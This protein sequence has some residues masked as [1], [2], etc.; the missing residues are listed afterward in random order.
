MLHISIR[1]TSA[2]HIKPFVFVREIFLRLGWRLWW[3]AFVELFGTCGGTFEWIF[4]IVYEALKNH[5]KLDLFRSVGDAR[6]LAAV[7]AAR[8]FATS[9]FDFETCEQ[10]ELGLLINYETEGKAFWIPRIFYRVKYF[11][12]LCVYYSLGSWSWGMSWRPTTFCI[13]SRGNEISITCSNDAI[14][15]LASV[16]Q[17]I[18]L[19]TPW[20]IIFQIIEWAWLGDT[21][22]NVI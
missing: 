13:T 18:H 8:V 10:T 15:W 19:I 16:S 4:W 22:S 20:R 17:N 7:A 1:Y 12:Y 3:V 14:H 11:F 21:C 9:P 5:L 6:H 2:A